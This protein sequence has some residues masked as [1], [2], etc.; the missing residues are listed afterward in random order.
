[1]DKKKSMTPGRFPLAMPI[2]EAMRTQRAIRRFTPDPVDEDLLLHLI[3]LATKAPA[4]G[5]RQHA[6]FIIVRERRQSP[7]RA[8][9]PRCCGIRDDGTIGPSGRR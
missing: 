8:T 1:M 9:E 2:E 7:T 6:E 5:G 3:E 4:G